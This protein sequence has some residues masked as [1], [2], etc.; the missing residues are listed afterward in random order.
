MHVTAVYIPTK[1]QQSDDCLRDQSDLELG[2]L[3]TLTF[4]RVLTMIL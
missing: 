1:D 4:P 2:Q 3:T